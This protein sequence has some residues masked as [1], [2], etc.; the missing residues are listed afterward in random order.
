[1][2]LVID[3]GNTNTVL[4]VFEGSHLRVDWRLET[5]QRQTAD[6]YGI[7]ARNL[8]ALGE[9]ESS[10]IQHIIIA[11]VV[12]P[13][14]AVLEQ[15]ALKYFKINH[16]LSSPELKRAWQSCMIRLPMWEQTG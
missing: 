16:C 8:F 12:P 11:S 6:E 15:M 7:L 5:K 9:I 4:G 14:N 13:L 2:L 10:R 3:I 1:M